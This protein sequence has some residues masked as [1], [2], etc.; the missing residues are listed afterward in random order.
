MKICFFCSCSVPIW[1]SIRKCTYTIRVNLHENIK[2]ESYLDTTYTLCKMLQ[3]NNTWT[4]RFSYM[5]SPQK[6]FYFVS[7]QPS[8][9]LRKGLELPLFQGM[10][11][12]RLP[13]LVA[14]RP[15]FLRRTSPCWMFSRWVR[16][17]ETGKEIDSS[18]IIF[19]FEGSDL[20]R[21]L[22]SFQCVDVPS[23][24][25][26]WRN[27]WRNRRQGTVS[28]VTLPYCWLYH[29]HCSEDVEWVRLQVQFIDTRWYYGF[30]PSI[31]E[32]DCRLV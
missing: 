28:F 8:F 18:G 30:L 13:R 16:R 7:I 12:F 31:P 10:F 19:R 2:K 1:I 22:P 29:R 27:L 14:T 23:R 20:R 9:S 25:R 21:N 24:R 4:A 32:C 17:G 6:Q 15:F 3:W 5:K 11:V 26:E